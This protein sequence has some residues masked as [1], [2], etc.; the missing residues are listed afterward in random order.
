VQTQSLRDI[1]EPIGELLE[2]GGP[3]L[4][5][6]FVLS[7]VLWTLIVERYVY[8]IWSYP[9][10]LALADAAW[11]ARGD[12]TSWFARQIRRAMISEVSLRL[13]RS[14]SM[15]KALIAVCPLLGLLGTVTGMIHVFDVMAFAGSGN[16]KAMADG[17]SMATIPTMAGMVVAISG[18][19]FSSNLQ[20]RAALET[21]RTADTLRAYRQ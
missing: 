19:F 18:L 3:V 16:A 21:Q 1:F 10:D 4:W 7:L 17:V 12:R 8:L 2:A 15:I 14:L 20:R 5:A 11:R 13:S 9:R 6:I